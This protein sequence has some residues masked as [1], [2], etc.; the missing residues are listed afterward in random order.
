MAQISVGL[1]PWLV[2][3]WADG[4]WKAGLWAVGLGLDLLLILVLSGNRILRRI[5][6]DVTSRVVARRR[7]GPGGLWGARNRS[8]AR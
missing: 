1:V 6:A 4:Q 5:E 2:S 8:S 3:I 7:S